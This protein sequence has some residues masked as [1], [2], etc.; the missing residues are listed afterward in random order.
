MLSNPAFLVDGLLVWMCLITDILHQ[1]CSHN[2]QL[3]QWGTL[4]MRY[5]QIS[6]L[7]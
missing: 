2:L 1:Q 6:S 5:L 3:G 4:K 7:D